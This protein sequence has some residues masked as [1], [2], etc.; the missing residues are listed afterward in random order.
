MQIGTQR[1]GFNQPQA[2]F[3]P[4]T[5]KESPLLLERVAREIPVLADGWLP[6]GEHCRVLQVCLAEAGADAPAL[7]QMLARF[8]TIAHQSHLEDFVS[9]ALQRG[10]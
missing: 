7:S 6:G 1:D 5:Q 10:A 9:Q 4:P 3:Q 2:D 8:G